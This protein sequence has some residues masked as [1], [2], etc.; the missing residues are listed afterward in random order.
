LLDSL[1]QESFGLTN[2]IVAHNDRNCREVLG[3]VSV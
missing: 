1:L 3:F 2:T